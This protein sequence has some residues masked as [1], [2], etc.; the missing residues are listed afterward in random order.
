MLFFL[1]GLLCGYCLHNGW[2]QGYVLYIHSVQY[3]VLLDLP[4]RLVIGWDISQSSPSP[5]KTALS[6]TGTYLK[7]KPGLKNSLFVRLQKK[8]WG[9][10]LRTV[11]TQLENVLT[12]IQNCQRNF[13]KPSLLWLE[14]CM[15]GAHLNCC[16][17]WIYVMGGTE[18][19]NN[20]GGTP[21][22]FLHSPPSGFAQLLTGNIFL[23]SY[24]PSRRF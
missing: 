23:A 1:K 5:C 22:S 6:L 3:I 24:P 20:P 16:G 7:R 4:N 14:W 8:I 17:F 19:L 9:Y 21:R 15:A 12:H 10:Q 13:C 11:W 18:T 2:W